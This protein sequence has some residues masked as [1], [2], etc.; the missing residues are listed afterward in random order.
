MKKANTLRFLFLE[1]WKV[2][3]RHNLETTFLISSANILNVGFY[4]A[5]P[6]LIC[7]VGNAHV[8]GFRVET[9]DRDS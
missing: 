5:T 9:S 4:E 6:I 7:K 1:T 3:L 8:L 2:M